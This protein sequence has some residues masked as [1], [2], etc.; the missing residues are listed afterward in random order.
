[1]LITSR[2]NIVS[3][4]RH[5]ENHRNNNITLNT[6][7]KTYL[8]LY[9]RIEKYPYFRVET[10]CTHSKGLLWKTPNYCSYNFPLA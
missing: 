6:C 10:F 3:L 4:P 7:F 8:W 5:T 9:C 1:M 2:V